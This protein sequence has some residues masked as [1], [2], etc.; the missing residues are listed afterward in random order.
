MKM[1]DYIDWYI[2]EN[3]R[4]NT[5]TYRRAKQ[6]AVFSH[7]GFLFF[8]PNM[9]KW[10]NLGSP[11]LAVS[12]FCVMIV[13]CLVSPLV[14]KAGSLTGSG[15][16]TMA[17]LCW[18]FTALTFMTGGISSS[19]IAWNLIIPLFAVTFFGLRMM[20]IWTGVMSVEIILLI[21]VHKIGLSLPMVE[22]SAEQIASTQIANAI[23]PFAATAISCYFFHKGLESALGTQAEA[24]HAQAESMEEQEKA[25]LRIE[26]MSQGLEQT[27][28]QVG[29]NTDHLVDVTLKEMDAKTKHTAANAGEANNLMKEVSKVIAD[30]DASMK[31]LTRSMTDITKA[32]ED[33]SKIVKTIDEIAFQTNLLA[34]NAAV[35]AARAGE[36]GAG[37]AV[38]ADEVRNLAMRSAESAKNTALMSENTVK[39]VKYGSDIVSKTNTAFIDVTTR[40]TKVAGIMD[41]I[42]ADTAD[43][44]HGIEDVNK[45]V[46]DID[47]LLQQ[48]DT[49]AL[50]NV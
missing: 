42:A 25:K 17:A 36:A 9:I 30:A 3:L 1:M 18:H 22:L 19:A 24:L 27:F 39:K 16:V 15:N 20:I 6:L 23:G 34:L 13:V 37:F 50:I 38:V 45:A 33:T 7:F 48:G 2:P 28:I 43:Q 4:Q 21:A 44:A 14:L 8:I 46:E 40:V 49:K 11:F 29:Q 47:Q 5:D 26:E 41:E 12:M 35:E 32:S 31:D 10:Y